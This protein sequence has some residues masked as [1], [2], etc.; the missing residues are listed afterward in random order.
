VV[1]RLSLARTLLTA[2]ILG[3][4]QPVASAHAFLDHGE[5]GVGADLTTSP[6]RIVLHFDSEIE[7]A[8]SGFLVQ[9]KSG[10][11]VAR[12]QGQG[13]PADPA[14]LSLVLPGPLA[15]GVYKVLWSVIAR[16]GHHTEGD[17]TFTIH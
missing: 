11:E 7:A 16:D 8:F 14:V 5:P 13:D 17:Y 6:Q 4:W 15:P 2:V 10:H 9:D 1:G 12:V 3:A